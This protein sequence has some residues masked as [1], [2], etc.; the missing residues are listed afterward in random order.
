MTDEELF[1]QY[2]SVCNE[3]LKKNKD[4]FPFKQIIA[5]ATLQEGV[6]MLHSDKVPHAKDE[7][8]V[9]IVNDEP[10]PSFTIRLEHDQIVSECCCAKKG[11]EC[12]KKWK[13]PKSY[14]LD[15]INNP[16]EYID[17]PAKINWEW[18]Q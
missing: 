17:N 3:A 13:I 4:K 12:D 10:E 1:Q 15:V 5:A 11:Q 16:D 8:E 2:L 14:M 9:C 18:L 6:P 7:I